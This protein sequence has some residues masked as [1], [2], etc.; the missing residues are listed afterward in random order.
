MRLILQSPSSGGPSSAAFSSSCCRTLSQFGCSTSPRCSGLPQQSNQR[1]FSSSSTSSSTSWS[2]RN[3]NLLELRG[4]GPVNAGLLLAQEITS[5]EKLHEIYCKDFKQDKEELLR[6]LSEIVGFRNPAHCR[7]VADH[8]EN[9][10]LKSSSPASIKLA[11]EGNIGAGKSTFLDILQDSSLELQDL[12]EV[13]PEPVEEWQKVHNGTGEPINLLDRF[14]K[15]P[16]RYAYTFQHYVLLTR[17][18]KDRK[19][20]ASLKPLRVLERS[21][22]SD[23]LV[24]V[25]AMHEAGFMGDLELRLY[26][27]WFSME[28]G[29]DQELTPDGFIYLK[30]RPETCIKRLRSRNRSEEAGVDRA[31]LENLHDKHESWLQFGARHV[32][33]DVQT[34]ASLQHAGSCN[35][36]TVRLGELH[37]DLLRSAPSSIRD[38]VVFLGPNSVNNFGEGKVLNVLS[39]VPALILDHE[40]DDILFDLDARRDY[41][42]KVKDFSNYVG[43]LQAGSA[44]QQLT[45]MSATKQNSRSDN[46]TIDQIDS[47]KHLISDYRRLLKGSNKPGAMPE[48]SLLAMEGKLESLSR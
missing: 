2:P 37:A 10:N 45:L 36:R 11:V 23:R 8:L 5:V 42:K 25:R 40:Q 32:G 18:E 26:D 4:V 48:G 39:G 41:A 20:R 47:L 19:A 35:G 9:L 44:R 3:N 24:F 16:E 15:E 17:M 22:F 33:N 28:I 46:L 27:S 7:S 21:I 31:Y 38:N 12:I 13:V 29:Q 6:F 43:S 1:T 30:A 34:K 14:Y